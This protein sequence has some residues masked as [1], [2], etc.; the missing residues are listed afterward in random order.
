MPWLEENMLDLSGKVTV[1]TGA[2]SGIGF[3]VAKAL[4]AKNALVIL[5]CRNEKKGENAVQVIKAD[6]ARAQV[7]FLQLDLSSL[8][9]VR[10]FS[11]SVKE[12]YDHLDIL[13]NNAGV[14]MVPEGKTSDGFETHFGTNHLGHFALTGHLFELLDGTPNSRI[15]PV[16]SIAHK[17]GKI[18]FYNL[19][20]EKSYNK[21]KA[22]SQ[23][24]LACLMFAYEL[25]RRIT[26]SVAQTTAIA[27]HPGVTH[28]NLLNHSR[29]LHIIS[30]LIEQ[31]THIGALSLVRA[32]VDPAARGGEFYGPDGFLD[33]RGNPEKAKSVKRSHNESVA[34]K[35]WQVSEEMTGIRF[36][37]AD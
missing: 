25:Q 18:D 2:N 37:S 31:E 34:R 32:A 1:V 30:R 5:G 35:L 33:M 23:S 26:Q 17:F 22:Y 13:I 8:A 10:A 3:E 16:S 14:M 9:S 20:A 24:K 19:N 29:L 11:D 15:V 36:L 12:Q 4:A 6:N 27:A 7:D 28:S 21:A